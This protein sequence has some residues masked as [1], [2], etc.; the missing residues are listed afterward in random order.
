MRGFTI[1]GVVAIAIG[2]RGRLPAAAK[3]TVDNGPHAGSYTL[4]ADSPCQITEQKP[5]KPRHMLYSLFGTPES[6]PKRFH[7]PKALTLLALSVPDADARGANHVFFASIVFG[8]EDGGTHYVIETRPTKP[9][10]GSGSVTL[11]QQGDNATAVFDVKTADGIGYHGTL[12]CTGVV[13]Y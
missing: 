8:E 11:T 5:P 4:E 6:D 3:V 2:L 1:L 12:V 9:N 10:K 7:D 13:R